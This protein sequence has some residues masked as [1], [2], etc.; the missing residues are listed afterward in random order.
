ME[1]AKLYNGV[2]VHATLDSAPGTTAT[3][4][5]D[6]LSSYALELTLKVK[7][8][9]ANIDLASLSKL[10]PALPQLLPGLG[11]LLPKAGVAP[12]YE[13]LYSRKLNLLQHDL[14]RL[15]LLISR[16]NF[17]DCETILELQN[18]A[19]KRAA[20][21]LQADMDVDTDG[22]DPDRLP[23]VDGNSSTFQPMTSYRWPK[24]TPLINPFLPGRQARVH[25]LELELTQARAAKAGAVRLQTL[26]EAIGSAKYEVAQLKANSF[27]MAE[28]DPF[29]VISP[30]MMEGSSAVFTSHIG[31]YCAVIVGDVIYPAIIGDLG[32]SYKVG[33]AS[34]R[35]ARQV[36]PAAGADVRAVTPLKATYLFFPNSAD[37]PFG[38]PNLDQWHARVDALLKELGGYNGKL[39]AWAELSRPAPTPT[40]PPTPTPVP[41]PTP[42]P[43][44]GG[45][46]APGGTPSP[47]PS[48]TVSPSP[49]AKPTPAPSP[50]ATPPVG[51]PTCP[52]PPA[53][54]FPSTTSRNTHS[55]PLAFP[56]TACHSTRV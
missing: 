43:G 3:A 56:A 37:K 12:A 14:V 32:P 55:F 19:T 15:D 41:S 31:D 4:E 39:W 21:L 36:N 34:Y 38:P 9:R 6:T 28:T 44:P 11:A 53:R 1:T 42:L 27:L 30:T 8:P 47:G 50:S 7:V 17:F 52:R 45:T 5:H 33:E 20:V 49:P 2:Q 24:R 54:P 18:S 46:P 13:A 26:R 40:P 22:S 25:A 23:A 51:T 10:N 48:P 29:V 16:H 35:V